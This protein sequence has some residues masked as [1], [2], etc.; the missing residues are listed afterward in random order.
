MYFLYLLWFGI[1]SIFLLLLILTE[2]EILSGRKHIFHPKDLF[3][4]LIFLSLAG[5]IGYLVDKH[6]IFKVIPFLEGL[7]IPPLFSRVAAYPIILFLLSLVYGPSK[8]IRIENRR[9][10]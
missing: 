9:G 6:L 4:Q 5:I 8:L 1:P 3:S 2:L 7:G 10:R